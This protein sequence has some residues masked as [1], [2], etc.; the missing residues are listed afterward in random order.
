MSALAFTFRYALRSLRRSGQRGALAVV[1]V[2]FGVFSLVSLQLFSASVEG[3]LLLPPRVKLGGDLGL[4]RDGGLSADDLAALRADPD[5]R[6]VETVGRV[7]A[8]FVQTVA[9]GRAHLVNRVVAVDPETFPIVGSVRL[10]RGTL[11]EALRQPGG[12]VVTADLAKTMGV[13]TGDRLRLAGTPGETPA[14]L[15]VTGV[16]ESTPD[17]QG[18]TVLVSAA[19]AR[20]ISPAPPPSGAR[21]LTR[22]P[23][24]VAARFRAAGWEAARPTPSDTDVERL[25]R[26]ALPSAGLLGLL[27][28]GIGVANTLQVV[29]TRRRTEVA[30]L[31]ALGYRQRDLLALFGTET[32]LLGLAGGVLGV[33]GGVAGAEA[34]RRVTMTSMPFLLDLRVVPSVL[35]GGLLAGLLTAVLFGTIAIVRASAVRPATLLRQIPVRVTGRSRAA[36][37]GLYLALFVL[38]GALGSGLLGSLAAGFGVLAGGLVALAVFGGLMLAVLMAVVRL[39]TPGLPLVRMAASNL[40]RQPLRAASSLV[41]LFAGTFAIGISGQA[42]LNGQSEVTSRAVASSQANL[43]VWGVDAD[44]PGLRQLAAEAGAAV[45]TDRTAP[46]AV[47]RPDGTPAGGLSDVTGRGPEA[48]SSLRVVDAPEDGGPLPWPTRPD[49]ALVPT[50]SALWADAPTALGD[51]LLLGE[52]P[53]VVA[54]F[55]DVPDG[56][57][58]VQTS[59]VVV[60]PETFRQLAGGAVTETVALEVPPARLAALADVLGAAYPDAAVVTGQDLADMVTG[61]VRGLFALVLALTSL[62]LVA[63]TVLIANGVGLAMIERRREL[64]VLKALGYSAGQVLRTVVLENAVLGAVAGG[65]GVGAVALTLWALG[66]SAEVPVTVYPGVSA[67]LVAVAV[68]LAAGSALAVAWRPVRARPLAVLRDE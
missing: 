26:L 58:L 66:R 53:V 28:G 41:A 27:L 51:T 19:T 50:W 37:V 39:P 2:A 44:D 7:D 65:A 24:R 64:G 3:A 54:G 18:G 46:A 22:A 33:A 11:A 21:V 34:L 17:A 36:T 61:V 12:A 13:A 31:K 14:T 42:I 5:V 29:L 52:T 9:S 1:C 43:V 60:A 62:A 55:Y 6:A 59:G 49:A 68:A 8:Q 40:R 63:G 38:F 16:A 4:S 47:R 45:W 67:A 48:A 20:A 23:D 32:A 25:L 57:P 10:T 30:T 15:T 35:I 56:L